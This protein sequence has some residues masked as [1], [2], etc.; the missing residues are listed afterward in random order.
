MQPERRWRAAQAAECQFWK[1]WRQI[2]VYKDVQLEE[3]WKAQTELLGLEPATLAGKTVL[4]LGCGPVG[5][6]NF[7]PV[8]GPRRAVDPLLHRYTECIR[9]HGIGFC[10]ARGEALPFPSESMD[11]VLC[12]NVLDHVAEAGTV[13]EEVRRLLRPGGTLY[14]MV[15]TFPS[16]LK[17]LLFF[18][19]MHTYHWSRD[20][21]RKLLESAGF[22]LQ[23]EHHQPRRFALRFADCFKPSLWRYAAGRLIIT[24]SYFTAQK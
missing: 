11:V 7:L 16:W 5:L 13:L 21:V 24:S 4:D 12:F 23:R 15:H 14:L 19:R 2:P 10:A 17:Q 1:R 6:I 22:R 3:Y 8:T 20:D 9:A 18:D